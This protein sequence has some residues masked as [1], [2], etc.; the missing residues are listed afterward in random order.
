MR[1][2]IWKKD[3][4]FKM[5]GAKDSVKEIFMDAEIVEFAEEPLPLVWNFSWDMK[6]EGQVTELRCEDGEISGEVTLFDDSHIKAMLAQIDTKETDLEK[7]DAM[8]IRI[9][10]YYG[11]VVRKEPV[12]PQLGVETVVQA[13]LQGVSFFIVAANPGLEDK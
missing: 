8:G 11:N 7:L 6:P 5:I 4:S 13:K 12:V 2:P 1:H 10:G 9:G 3:D